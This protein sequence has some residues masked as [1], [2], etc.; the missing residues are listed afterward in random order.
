MSKY[1]KDFKLKATH[2]ATGPELFVALRGFFF[3]AAKLRLESD[4]AIRWCQFGANST[5]SSIPYRQVNCNNF[6]KR[7][8]GLEII[9][10]FQVPK[11]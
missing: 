9:P 4:D 5:A 8:Q 10:F 11:I 6:P 2:L 1:S 7:D 3:C